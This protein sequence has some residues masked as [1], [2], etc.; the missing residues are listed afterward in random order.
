MKL[1]L[2]TSAVRKV[3]KV[4]TIHDLFDGRNFSFDFVVADLNG[5]HGAYVNQ[6]SDRVY[7][8]LS[9]QGTVVVGSEK[10]DVVKD[11]LIVVNKNTPH[12]I[13]GE[14]SFLI[15]TAPPFDPANEQSVTS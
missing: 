1:S 2:A 5:N 8:I 13:A 11:D 15:I 3:D 9:G 14:L 6:V 12:L 4:L 7:F 10:Y